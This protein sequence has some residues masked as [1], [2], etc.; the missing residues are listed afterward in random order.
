MDSDLT[1]PSFS[2]NSSLSTTSDQ[3]DLIG[4][5]LQPHESVPAYYIGDGFCPDQGC[6]EAGRHPAVAATPAS[7]R[8]HQ[9]DR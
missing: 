5:L 6:S 2:R 9:P 7:T 3:K 4:C 1:N 8:R